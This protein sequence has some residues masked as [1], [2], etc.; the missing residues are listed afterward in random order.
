VSGRVCSLPTSSVNRRWADLERHCLRLRRSSLGHAWLYFRTNPRSSDRLQCNRPSRMAVSASS[1]DSSSRDV[2]PLARSSQH[3]LVWSRCL[4][5]RTRR[6][7]LAPLTGA[8]E[9]G[10]LVFMPPWTFR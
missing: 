3:H 2:S 5:R 8:G 9:S 1:S 10:G 7:P 6:T 4:R